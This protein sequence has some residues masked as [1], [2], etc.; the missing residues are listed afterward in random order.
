[1]SINVRASWMN[2]DRSFQ[3]KK[4][5]DKHRC[6]RN[7]RN[8]NLMGPTWLGNQFLKEL[9]RKPNLKCKEMQVII[10][11]RFHCNVSWSKC[12]RAK[13]RAMSL[14]EGRLSDHYVKVW[15]CGGELLR[16]NRGSSIKIVMSQNQDN[17]T[18]FQRMYICVKAIKKDGRLVVVG[19]LG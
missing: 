7:Y 2:T 13:C 10:Q 1:M 19:L 18:T 8:T 6:V 4:L 3:I 5:V 16:S 11:S 12:Y 17:T 14:I 9:I 15:D